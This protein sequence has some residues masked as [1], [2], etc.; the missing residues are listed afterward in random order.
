MNFVPVCSQPAAQESTV[1]VCMWNS[2]NMK[3]PVILDTSICTVYIK[4]TVVVR[5][6]C[7]SFCTVN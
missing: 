4:S 6:A 1:S 2:N 3:K 5:T 7:L